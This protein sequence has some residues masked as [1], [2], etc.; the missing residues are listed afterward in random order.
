M[1]TYKTVDDPLGV[2]GTEIY[3]VN[4]N[5]EVVGSY[6]DASD[7]THG[8]IDV[9]GTFTTIDVPSATSTV[10][11][12]VNDSGEI[13][14][15]YHSS[16][17]YH[18][19]IDVG[20]VITTLDDPS[21]TA[22]TR[23]YGI[24]NAGQVVG[25]YYGEFNAGAPYG[26]GFLYT[27]GTYA[28][29]NDPGASINYQNN[30]YGI[31]NLGE[32]VGFYQD[33]AGAVGGYTYDE[34]G[35][36]ESNGTFLPLSAPDAVAP[37]GTNATGVNDSGVIVGYYYTSG[38]VGHGFLYE[39]SNYTILNDPSAGAGGY[40][41]TYAEGINNAGEIVGYY[42]NSKG[43]SKGFVLSPG[44]SVTPETQT[45]YAPLA[46]TS[47]S[48]T[49]S[50]TGALT[51]LTPSNGQIAFKDSDQAQTPT[52]S[53]AMQNV[54]A[55][56]SMGNAVALTAGQIQALENDFTITTV[57]NGDGSGT[58]DWKYDASAANLPSLPPDISID[59]GT[60]I[61]ISDNDGN[62]SHATVDVDLE[63]PPSLLEL[64]EMDKQAYSPTPAGV[65]DWE[66]L[67]PPVINGEFEGVLYGN[68][69]P[70]GPNQIVLAIRGTVAPE[71]T[72]SVPYLLTSGK[73]ILTDLASFPSGTPTPG[74]NAI[75]QG[76][77]SMLSAAYAKYANA[78]FTITGHSLGG[79]AAQLVGDAANLTSLTFNGN[80]AQTVASNAQVEADLSPIDDIGAL[81]NPPHINYRDPGDII[82]EA[83]TQTGLQVTI[84]PAQLPYT[85]TLGNWLTAHG[86]QSVISFLSADTTTLTLN[87]PEPANVAQV[88]PLIF[89][90]G[91][92]LETGAGGKISSLHFEFQTADKVANFFDPGSALFFVFNEAAGSPAITAITLSNEDPAVTSFE[93][94]TANSA[95]VYGSPQVVSAGATISVNDATGVEFEGLSAAGVPEALP[96]SYL[97]GL[98]FGATATV[99]ADLEEDPGIQASDAAANASAIEADPGYQVEVYDTLANIQAKSSAL[100]GLIATG[101]ISAL[102]ATAVSGEAYGSYEYDYD[103]YGSPTI[104]QFFFAGGGGTYSS[105]EYDYSPG[106]AFIGSKF[107]Y[108]GAAN[109]PDYE[110]NYDGGGN[111]TRVAFTSDTTD[112][113]SSYEYD[114]VGGVY[115]GSKFTFT[116]GSISANYSYYQTDYDYANNFTGEQFFF[117]DLTG[118]PYTGEEEDF[119]AGGVLTRVVL[120]GVQDQA[121]SSLEEDYS[122]G[123]YEGY[124]AYYTGITGQPYTGEEVDVSASNEIEKV[125][126]SG[127]TSTPYSSVEEDYSGGALSDVIYGFTKVT[128]QSYYAYQ[129]E[130]SASG[131]GL[132]ETFDL[133]SGGH[134][135][136]ALTAGQTL[137]SLGDD[138]MTGSG[139]TTFVLNAVYA[140]DVI[141]NLTSLDTVS[142]PS[143]EFASFTALT[144]AATQSGANVVIAASDG[145]TLT[146]KNMNTA[147]LAVMTGNFTFHA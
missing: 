52:A 143:S 90:T 58:V 48:P 79:A 4:N 137:T 98:A 124:K 41:G 128:G 57:Q 7:D 69:T 127:M 87:Y 63:T 47:G 65:D 44:I 49:I 12:G 147:Q 146:L 37:Y 61:D 73:T 133:N 67:S 39:D 115:A 70:N 145:D 27:N 9:D 126:Y 38:L 11:V 20:G 77:A 50:T 108:T 40:E 30:A 28:T 100:K 6:Q 102:A 140:A 86:L 10:V 68:S 88:P 132:Q 21:A 78:N 97:L 31:N 104:K 13:S 141:T 142:L 14:G 101:H 85:D 139:A 1:S 2:D 107:Y 81:P 25:F 94:W 103:M 60:T 96:S 53:I 59:V 122:A 99:T 8:F 112:P 129:V 118:L 15:Y 82:S 83:G 46:M 55:T 121:Y 26:N 64:A 51:T 16:T 84:V 120:T 80:G 22:G 136:V 135:L 75:L 43:V 35:Y 72:T 109:A 62:S 91:V 17:G 76:A 66:V 33:T 71:L 74:L 125:V 5:G 106:N 19:F 29:I 42:V 3:G 105:Y 92:T 54:T 110:Y 32:I 114:Y 138:K 117:T 45:V 23:A 131:S 18:G 111:V 119:D 93:V 34:Y 134:T 89:A 113:F 24:N 130:D 123:T 36:S 116:A 144:N 56:D 95:G